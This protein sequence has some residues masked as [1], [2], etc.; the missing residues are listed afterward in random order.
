M[1]FINNAVSIT[2]CVLVYREMKKTHVGVNCA[3]QHFNVPRIFDVIVVFVMN[4]V[5]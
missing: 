3:L 2:I 1:C 5:I 4:E